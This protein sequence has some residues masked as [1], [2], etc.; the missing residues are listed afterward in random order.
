MY[1]S[2]KHA[3]RDM[4]SLLTNENRKR[5]NEHAIIDQIDKVQNMEGTYVSMLR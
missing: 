2:S 1:A 4:F 3:N 5:T